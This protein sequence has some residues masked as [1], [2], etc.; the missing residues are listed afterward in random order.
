MFPKHGTSAELLFLLKILQIRS[1]LAV[2]ILEFQGSV[3][4]VQKGHPT[5]VTRVDLIL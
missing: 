5:L 1:I 4:D 2:P 3:R